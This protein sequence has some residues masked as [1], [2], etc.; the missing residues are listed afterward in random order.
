MSPPCGVR[1]KSSTMRLI[2][3][4]FVRWAFLS[5]RPAVEGAQ[6]VLG[7]F[8]PFPAAGRERPTGAVDIKVQHGHGGAKRLRL[9]TPALLGGAP[10]GTGDG[11]GI[12]QRE[13][14]G[15]QRQRIAG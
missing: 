7:G 12:A 3:S 9:A 14:A 2:L 15:L 10:Q 8:E 11:L 4:F 1:R 6:L 5:A 13:H